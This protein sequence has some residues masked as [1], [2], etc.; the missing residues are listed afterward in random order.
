MKIA[1][2]GLDVVPSTGGS[3]KAIG[4]FCQVTDSMVI[5][6]TSQDK[7]IPE[8]TVAANTIHV[9]C[10]AGFWGQTFA[11]APQNNRM[12]ADVSIAKTDVLVCHIL[13]RYHVHW[14]KAH[15]KRND[16][17]YWVVPHGCLDPYVFSYRSL[18][19]RI[20]FYFFGRP[21]LKHASKVIFATE[22]EKNKASKYYT[23]EN[24]CV[25]HWPVE[26]L[27]CSRRDLV[28][29]NVRNKHGIEPQD[30]ILIYLGRLHPSKR[31]LETIKSFAQAEVPRTHLLIVGPEEKISRQEC[32]NLV[33]TLG[34]KN[35]HMVGP[36]YG[37][38]KYD[39]L[40]AADAYISL[41]IKENFG[42]TAA[43]ALTAG[44]PVILSP[45]NDLADELSS[46]ACGWMLKDDQLE[47]AASAIKEFSSL[48]T[49]ILNDMG[50]R[51][52]I[53]ATDNFDPDKFSKEVASL[54]RITAKR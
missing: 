39:Y 3:Y 7:Q 33:Q 9:T 44:L 1:H 13:W 52:R 36:I 24:C 19:K 22:K 8:S 38:E 10:S 4:D 27:N 20:W 21:F 5:S 51:G 30:K 48:S 12:E 18:I 45:G 40:L 43:E 53:W 28:R 37:E 25:I 47:T 41:S 2:V 16:I 46:L 42:Y 15:A 49:A 26:A 23:G 50:Q 17:P 31:P 34:V 29:E 11:W 35:V 14:V 54:L 6:F 32:S